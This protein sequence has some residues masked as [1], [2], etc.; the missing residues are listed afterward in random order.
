VLILR[1]GR[2]EA[3]GPPAQVLRRPIAKPAVQQVPP[4]GQSNSTA[5]V[6]AS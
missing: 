1:S 4:G 2:V 3:T 5:G 6:A